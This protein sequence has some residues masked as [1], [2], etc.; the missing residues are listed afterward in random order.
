MVLWVFSI[1]ADVLVCLLSA[2]M[3]AL[4]LI[5]S[6]GSPLPAHELMRLGALAGTIK[7][8]LSN[9]TS[10]LCKASLSNFASIVLF[11][12][13]SVIVTLAIVAVLAQQILGNGMFLPLTNLTCSAS[14]L[15][16]F[17]TCFAC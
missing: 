1:V 15:T 6:Q 10:L 7:A 14:S 17:S 16:I 4:V 13:Y 12:T 2:L 3:A 8:G 11:F 9:M 5:V